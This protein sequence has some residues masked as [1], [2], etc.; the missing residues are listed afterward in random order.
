MADS[1]DL[2]LLK[3]M[4][5]LAALVFSATAG[6][7]IDS[8]CEAFLTHGQLRSLKS[9]T[10]L[11]AKVDLYARTVDGKSEVVAVV[12]TPSSIN[13]FDSS[14]VRALNASFSKLGIYPARGWWRR[15]KVTGVPTDLPGLGS[16]MAWREQTG[17][18]TG[19]G[20]IF[21]LE[22]EPN[23]M[24]RLRLRDVIIFPG[25]LVA[26][27]FALAWPHTDFAVKTI[28][29]VTAGAALLWQGIKVFATNQATVLNLADKIRQ[30]FVDPS[31]Q[32]LVLLVEPQRGFHISRAL[33]AAGFTK[34]T[35]SSEPAPDGIIPDFPSSLNISPGLL[36]AAAKDPEV[37]SHLESLSQ[38]FEKVDS[39]HLAQLGRALAEFGDP[40]LAVEKALGD[41]LDDSALETLAQIVAAPPSRV[42]LNTEAAKIARARQLLRQTDYRLAALELVEA[43]RG[44]STLRKYLYKD[45]LPTLATELA[46]ADFDS[47]RLEKGAIRALIQLT[48]A[49][50]GEANR[51][52][53]TEAPRDRR[54]KY[55]GRDL[56][57]R[58][59]LA[60]VSVLVGVLHQGLPPPVLAA[61]IE[62]TLVDS[63]QRTVSP[64]RSA[65][66][67]LGTARAPGAMVNPGTRPANELTKS[68]HPSPGKFEIR[69]FFAPPPASAK[70]KRILP[71]TTDPIP[72]KDAGPLPIHPERDLRVLFR[73]QD[74]E[75]LKPHFVYEFDFSRTPNQPR[76][77]VVFAPK[78]LR[79]LE[80][81]SAF[82]RP[83]LEA[84]MS[85]LSR[86]DDP[87]LKLLLGGKSRFYD[88]RIW[89]I[90]IKGNPRGLVI[91]L[92]NV[93]QVLD[94]AAK[95]AVDRK[96]ENLKPLQDLF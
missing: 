37:R 35:A 86:G 73:S 92:D 17:E 3:L 89:E 50:E 12:S 28:S 18:P 88:G 61:D 22:I 19:S 80:E 84:M 29:V 14:V 1:M 65:A 75:G 48:D 24:K 39:S 62:R 59:S 66:P 90:K 53:Q 45:Y 47:S 72:P 91:R 51:L 85:G 27:S 31:R 38:I 33:S 9:A 20:S 67:N 54:R 26:A 36:E 56:P 95:N 64:Y 41:L 7:T 42:I 87:G 15:P 46:R 81:N 96:C 23:V 40:K 4:G 8:G 43:A 82:A 83:M 77:K 52:Y 93:W 13:Q 78:A 71:A 49:I 21:S 16:S 25:A 94:V 10:E 69:D 34:V 68:P 70:R 44:R 5:G 6:A 30:T 63:T 32:N 76:Q 11:Q 57:I 58:S 55:F 60:V 2:Y 74:V 79:W